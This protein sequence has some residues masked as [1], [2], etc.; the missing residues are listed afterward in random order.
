MHV[1]DKNVDKEEREPGGATGEPSRLLKSVFSSSV[2]HLIHTYARTH[3]QTNTHAHLGRFGRTY[4]NFFE[5]RK[6]Q[7][8]ELQ[9]FDGSPVLVT[10]DD[11]TCTVFS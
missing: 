7:K 1:V 8:T 6:C 10:R 5:Q 2:P 4:S 3:K 11:Y 9:H